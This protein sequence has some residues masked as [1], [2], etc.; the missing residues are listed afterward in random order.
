M[1]GAIAGFGRFGFNNGQTAPDGLWA[2]GTA[3]NTDF[4]TIVYQLRL[5]GFNGIRLPFI[6]K[7]GTAASC[8]PASR[9]V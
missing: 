1:P 7:V 5:L 6:F 4:A 2:G 8:T 3:A 9:R